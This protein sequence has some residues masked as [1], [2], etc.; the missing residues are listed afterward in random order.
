V[1]ASARVGLS[2]FRPDHRPPLDLRL[3]WVMMK[4]CPFNGSFEGDRR[5]TCS[6][7]RLMVIPS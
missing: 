6:S 7:T 3:T 2:S 5:E 4:V 1:H